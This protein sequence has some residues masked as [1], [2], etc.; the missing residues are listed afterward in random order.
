L[1]HAVDEL[2]S[3]PAVVFQIVQELQNPVFDVVQIE[4]LLRNDPALTTA[5]LRVVNSPSFG[6]RNKVASLRQAIAFLGAR[7]LRLVVL[8]FG[9]V[10]RLTKGAPAEVCSDYWR[11][12]LTMAATASRLASRCDGVARDEAY[13]AGLVADLGVLVFT[14]A[15]TTRYA[16]LYLQHPHGPELVAA[17]TK[18]FGAA[19][20]EL[21]AR[22]LGRWSLPES[23][24]EAVGGHH[25]NDPGDEP[26]SR[27]VFA[28][29]QLADALW[30]PQTP[31]LAAIRQ[32]FRR[33]F[34]LD[35]DGFIALAVDCKRDILSQA[36]IFCVDLQG[37]IDCEALQAHAQRQYKAEALEV[38]MDWDS[39]AS[40]LQQTFSQ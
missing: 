28:G 20:P 36:E 9:L 21:G 23:I 39:T 14:Q 18:E 29:D 40:V 26:I 5:V 10:D 7:T 17:E 4:R 16:R 33:E 12:A 15:E 11:R 2:H 19:H 34:Q 27:L 3:S 32:F 8:S 13:A 22:L 35:L 6:L 1:L 25:D 31:R 38:S 24:T 30:N 37:S